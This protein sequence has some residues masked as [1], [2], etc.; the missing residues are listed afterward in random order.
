MVYA[1]SPAKTIATAQEVLNDP[2]IVAAFASYRSAP[3][4]TDTETY[5]LA[6]QWIDAA[7]LL[8][9]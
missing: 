6:M 7:N 8:S 9:S 1:M 5:R 2:R 3:M 4:Q